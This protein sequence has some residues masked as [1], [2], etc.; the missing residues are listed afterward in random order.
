MKK[1][2]NV[3]ELHPRQGPRAPAQLV[4][5]SIVTAVMK[6]K[7]QP[8]R[9][10]NWRAVITFLAISMVAMA[11][12]ALVPAAADSGIRWPAATALVVSVLSAGAA[13]LY[14]YAQSL[15]VPLR[16]R[17]RPLRRTAG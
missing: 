6:L 1:D 11:G 3:I 8:I 12:A 9:Q 10:V 14:R 15:W 17:R 2:D 16:V 4:E 5:D 7:E 13:A